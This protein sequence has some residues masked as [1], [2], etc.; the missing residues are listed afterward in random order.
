MDEKIEKAI[1]DVLGLPMQI[2]AWPAEKLLESLDMEESFEISDDWR[3]EIL[4]RCKQIDKSRV[5]LKDAEEVFKAACEEP[6]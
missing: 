5:E 1:N 6:G 2:R 3:Q 4:S